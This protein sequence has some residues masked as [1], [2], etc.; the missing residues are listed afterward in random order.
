MLSMY[1]KSLFDADIKMRRLIFDPQQSREGIPL[2]QAVYTD[3][4]TPTYTHSVGERIMKLSDF[5][6]TV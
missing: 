3:A 2:S 6:V 1:T 4:H 5:T